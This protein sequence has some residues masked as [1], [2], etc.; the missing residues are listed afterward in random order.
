MAHI[1][2]ISIFIYFSVDIFFKSTKIFCVG[3]F[4]NSLQKN[5]LIDLLFIKK[6]INRPT[7]PWATGRV[8]WSPLAGLTGTRPVV[9][10]YS[11]TRYSTNE[12]RKRNFDILFRDNAAFSQCLKYLLLF[13]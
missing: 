4:K 5:N 7:G 11:I 6:K 10:H 2:F 3:K 8:D 13:F 12:W 9:D 1:S